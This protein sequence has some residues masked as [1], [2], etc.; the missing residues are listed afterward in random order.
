[1]TDTLARLAYRS[2]V[3]LATLIV[4]A[5]CAQASP[6]IASPAPLASSPGATAEDLGECFGARLVG[7]DGNNVDLTGTWQL[8]G[9]GPYYFISQTGV[10]VFMAGG[11]PADQAMADL[12]NSPFGTNTVVF[13]D[14]IDQQ[15]VVTG[16]F[17]EVR[18]SPNVGGTM[19]Y[20]TQNWE[21]HFTDGK[22]TELRTV[23]TGDPDE[24][25]PLTL[26]KLSDSFLE[27][28]N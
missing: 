21:V 6:D 16:R 9:N 28:L 13:Q 4:V 1:M 22:P 3:A 18:H 19:H 2:S 25:L 7:P 17:S 8:S 10:C 20:G 11:F 27:P 23:V 12:W 26:T 24:N 5:G 14:E 15:F